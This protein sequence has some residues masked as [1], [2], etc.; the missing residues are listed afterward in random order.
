M[1]KLIVGIIL[2][3]GLM[4]VQAEGL[5]S[6]PPGE[7]QQEEFNAF[8]HADP[9]LPYSKG[10]LWRLEKDGQ[11]KGHIFG[12]IHLDYPSVTRL[13]PQVRLIFAQSRSLLLETVL[14]AEAHKTYMASIY[15][16]DPAVFSLAG[17]LSPE[18]AQKARSLLAS[19]GLPEDRQTGLKPWAIFSLL[20]RP[21]AGSGVVLDEV[22]R[23]MANQSHKPV[24]GMETMQELI[25]TLDS[26][27]LDD[28]ITILVDT[29]CQHDRLMSSVRDLLEIYAA[30]DLAAL[31][32]IN[33]QPH[34]DEDVFRRFMQVML[35]DRND[36]MLEGILERLQS[37]DVFIAVGALHLPGER[38]LLNRLAQAGYSV[39]A[40]F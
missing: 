31:A 14:D 2:L 26:V 20:G 13:P 27:P 38:G 32:A 8:E 24:Y 36:H 40:V 16:D 23:Q 30:R 39:S 3:F 33:D 35:L 37:G 19:Y 10:L 6:C 17:I 12:T 4:P 5:H 25:S 11:V 29:L 9:N 1:N 15:F 22:L 21:K 7:Q 34:D 28:Q 18:L